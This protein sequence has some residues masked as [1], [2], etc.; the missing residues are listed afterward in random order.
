[1]VCWVEDG[2]KE[3]KERVPLSLRKAMHTPFPTEDNKGGPTRLE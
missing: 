3:T 1:M 2:Y